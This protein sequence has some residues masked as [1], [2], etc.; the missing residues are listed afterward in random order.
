MVGGER[1]EAVLVLKCFG[2]FLFIVGLMPLK[3]N[4]N[5]GICLVRKN[6]SLMK[7]L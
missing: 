4:K 6:S 7:C 2:F 1:K 3:E 5:S